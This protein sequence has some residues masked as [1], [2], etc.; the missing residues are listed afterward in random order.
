LY[1]L[2]VKGFFYE[3]HFLYLILYSYCIF[4]MQG[5]VVAQTH[6]ALSAMCDSSTLEI[7]TLDAVMFQRI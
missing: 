1:A 6:L 3:Q 7:G 5:H 2:P 4:E